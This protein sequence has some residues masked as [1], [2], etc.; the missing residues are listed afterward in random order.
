MN[1]EHNPLIPAAYDVAWS[2]IAA[3]VIALVVV[4][5]VS[6]ARSA[7]S[8]TPVQTLIWALIV[9]FVPVLGSVAWLAVGRRTTAR[10]HSEQRL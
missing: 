9:L 7:K 6:L 2:A 8:L 5:L 3:V 10:E 1:D 4:A